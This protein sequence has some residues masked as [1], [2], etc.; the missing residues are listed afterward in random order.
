[1]HSIRL[2]IAVAAAAGFGVLG[3]AAACGNGASTASPQYSVP[4]GAAAGA[5][6]NSGITSTVAVM[7]LNGGQVL[8]DSS[9][10]ALYT[11]DQDTG[12]KPM[13]VSKDCVSIWVPLTVPTGQQPTAAPGIGGTISTVPVG[14]GMDQVTLNGKPLYTFALD[15]RGQAHG[16]G[17]HDHFGSVSFT[18]HSAVPAGAVAPAAP[19]APAIPGY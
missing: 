5:G 6:Q 10:A 8:V 9:G 3:L 14:G 15:G 12:G 18:W 16:N 19:S 11:N 17:F 13:C 7:T 1:M 4:T 2:R